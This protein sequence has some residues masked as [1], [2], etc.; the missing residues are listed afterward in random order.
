MTAR[1]LRERV[2]IE[3]DHIR[4]RS[5]IGYDK[6]TNK[7]LDGI[8]VEF[9]KNYQLQP[10]AINHVTKGNI[11][12]WVAQN[13]NETAKIQKLDDFFKSIDSSYWDI[14]AKKYRGAPVKEISAYTDHLN[15]DMKE[16]LQSEL[17]RQSHNYREQP[18]LLHMNQTLKLIQNFYLNGRNP[19]V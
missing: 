3:R 18:G 9:P 8:D 10:K 5:T 19:K 2:R 1:T 11:E 7:I 14:N 12:R 17:H 6:A 16:L 13:P 15:I 4:G